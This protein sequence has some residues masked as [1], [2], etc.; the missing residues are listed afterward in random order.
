MQTSILSSG[1]PVAVA[2]QISDSMKDVDIVSRFNAEASTDMQFGIGVKPG[3]ARNAVN[4][5][6]GTSDVVEG[7]TT[8]GFNHAPGSTS[9]DL[10]QSNT[11]PGVAPK[12]SLQIMQR[13]R[14]YVL[15]D[16]T[17]SS[18]V[19][20]VDRGFCRAVSHSG[21]GTNVGGWTNAADSGDT[22]DCTKQTIFRSGVFT[23]AD[24]VSKIAE[25][26]VAFVNHP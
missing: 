16:S 12:G 21:V 20:N 11:P 22:I 15:L 2:G 1:Q 23:S 3:T 14:I 7:I 26:E 25:L 13:G 6:S 18:I 9:G 24:G 17:L 4:M 19:P 10:S 5:V 8:F